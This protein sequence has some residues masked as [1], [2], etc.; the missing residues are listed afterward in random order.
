MPPKRSART[1]REV[2][3]T[4]FDEPRAGQPAPTR[5]FWVESLMSSNTTV[6]DFVRGW[7]ITY[8]KYYEF[9][10]AVTTALQVDDLYKKNFQEKEGLVEI[11]EVIDALEELP[12]LEFLRKRDALRVWREGSLK[13]MISTIAKS[14]QNNPTYILP[15]T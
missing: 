13:G 3:Q 6:K 10:D 4:R 15:H 11:G 5:A 7:D 14:I 9:E 2:D 8:A 1:N 12:N